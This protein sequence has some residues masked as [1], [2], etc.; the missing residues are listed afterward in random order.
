[1]LLLYVVDLFLIGADELIA[2]TKRKLDAGFEMKDLGM[3]HYSLGMNVWQ[4]AD[5][6]SLG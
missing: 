1:M 4:N 2:D 6:I 5:G 3:M